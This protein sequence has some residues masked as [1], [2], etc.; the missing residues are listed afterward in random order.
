MKKKSSGYV[1]IVVL[2]V[3]SVLTILGTAFL[4]FSTNENKIVNKQK[5]NMQAYYAARAG[6]D[7]IAS[8]LVEYP[9][10]VTTLKNGA[11]TLKP[12]SGNLNGFTFVTSVT[13]GLS[14]NIIITS[15]AYKTSDLS[16]NYLANVSLKMN[17]GTNL[18]SDSFLICETFDKRKTTVKGNVTEDL[19]LNLPDTNE[20]L[21][22]TNV[23]TFVAYPDDVYREK[24]SS[25]SGKKSSN[26]FNDFPPGGKELHLFVQ[27]AMNSIGD[28]IPPE[29]V[30]LY[31]YYNGTND[32]FSNGKFTIERCAIYAPNAVADITGGGNGNFSGTLIAKNILLPNSN[33]TF[34]KDTL[35]NNFNIIGVTKTFSRDTWSS[36]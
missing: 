2:C 10:Q 15:K 35:I 36:N 32:I 9:N 31:I 28:I 25:L 20:A 7:A 29:G 14:G 23:D 1:L 16:K 26:I 30:A 8:Y 17:S 6:A 13:D 4:S 24:V 18:N 19:T 12:C 21:F 5:D 22:P 3:F 11:T 27:N 34:Q 33:A